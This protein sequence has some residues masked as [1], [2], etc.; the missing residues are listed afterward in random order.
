MC[1]DQSDLLKKVELVKTF[2]G[3]VTAARGPG[4]RAGGRGPDNPKTLKFS[5]NVTAN[6]RSSNSAITFY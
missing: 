5:G 3:S 4:M 1:H 2:M 6:F